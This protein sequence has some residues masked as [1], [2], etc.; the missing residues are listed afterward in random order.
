MSEI[1]G[2]ENI[3][4]EI[5]NNLDSGKDVL[6]FAFN[7]TG[8]TRLSRSF[9]TG[10][11]ST[12]LCYNAYVED[13][14]IWDNEEKIL[15]FAENDEI[16]SFLEE[17]GLDHDI[18]D[19]FKDC[20]GTKIEPYINFSS[21]TIEF[22]LATGDNESRE[23]VKVSKGEEAIFK[24]AVYKVL[25]EHALQSRQE[26]SDEFNNLKYVVID[27]PI[28]SL[29]D[30]RVCIIASQIINLLKKSR[31]QTLPI[32]FL[33]T[34]HHLMFFNILKSSLQND[35]E[36][37]REKKIFYKMEKHDN[38]IICE[39]VKGNKMLVYHLDQLRSIKQSIQRNNITK[40]LFN[41]LR[42]VLEKLAVMLGYDHWNAMFKE[43]E[44]LNETEF[45]MFVNSLNMNSHNQYSDI[46]SDQI[47]EDQKEIFIKG[48]NFFVDKFKIKL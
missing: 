13:S 10:M 46:D 31:Q 5:K 27:D 32:R 1:I 26:A 41:I 23:S 35:I 22:K 29:D 7:A 2:L 45:E 24:W 43:V 19:T 4:V 15:K 36:L 34:T 20:V 40:N 14:Y 44:G 38:E 9:D 39:Q 21:H 8:K 6:L 12:S 37:K 47:P 11:N 28:T 3:K 48:F 25:I 33:I 18:V 42:S 16:F 30:Y 17:N